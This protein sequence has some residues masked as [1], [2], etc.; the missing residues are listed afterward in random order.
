MIYWLLIYS[1]NQVDLII[2]SIV[3]NLLFEFEQYLSDGREYNTEVCMCND[4]DEIEDNIVCER[5]GTLFYRTI[6]KC[7]FKILLPSLGK[8]ASNTIGVSYF[9]IEGVVERSVSFILFTSFF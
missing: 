4:V 5:H 7:F 1:S 6:G 3:H 9:T 8:P 2:V